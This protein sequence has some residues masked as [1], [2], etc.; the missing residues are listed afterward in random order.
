MSKLLVLNEAEDVRVPFLRGILVRSLQRAGVDF[1]KAYEI[2]TSVREELKD[3][4]E[5]TAAELRVR[6]AKHLD[7]NGGQIADRYGKRNGAPA[8]IVVE[9]GDG[10]EAQ[11]SRGR[12]RLGLL[13][14]GLRAEKAVSVAAQIHA[15]L[16]GNDIRRIHHD[17]LRRTTHRLLR[18]ASGPKAAKRY[19]TW[20]AMR[21][22]GRSL[23]V[24]VGG[25]TGTG[26]STIAAQLSHVLD[27]TRT[28]STDMLREAMRM[29]IPER[30]IPV[31]HRSTFDAWESL[32][33][34]AWASHEDKIAAGYLAQTNVLRV[35][36]GAVLGRAL[37]E[38]LSMVLE[39]IHVH[40]SLLSEVEDYA[41]AVVVPVILGVLKPK[42]LKRRIRGRGST[43]PARRAKRYLDSFDD[44]WTLQTFLLA[45]ADRT[46]VPIV[47]NDDIEQTVR[48]VI[49]A[50]LRVLSKQFDTSPEAVLA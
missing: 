28:Q 13:C 27:V 50:I 17:E 8:A 9:Y 16:I 20:Q 49:L 25:A 34:R 42:E 46:G 31:L 21:R 38:G 5:I 47:A 19:L 11:Y 29:M 23:I 45:E 37:K 10:S 3:L 1:D 6:V 24:L 32:P 36:C 15:H 41:D 43:I 40:P 35:S 14:A 26:K 4:Q 44:I 33:A 22:S 18:E 12:Q 30:L 2:A 7:F 39:G 48:D